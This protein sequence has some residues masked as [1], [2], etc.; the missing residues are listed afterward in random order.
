MMRR[1]SKESNQEGRETG[2]TKGAS[3]K[4]QTPRPRAALVTWG[5]AEGHRSMGISRSQVAAWKG[6]SRPQPQ[7]G[8]G[9]GGSRDEI[10]ESS[11]MQR[12]RPATRRLAAKA[13]RTPGS[14][15]TDTALTWLVTWNETEE[16]LGTRAGEPAPAS[17]LARSPTAAPGRA[18]LGVGLQRQPALTLHDDSAGRSPALTAAAAATTASAPARSGRRHPN[19]TA[20]GEVNEGRSPIPGSSPRPTEAP[21]RYHC[22]M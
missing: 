10:P 18:H 6:R 14:G 7:T 9:G 1:N 20:R 2:N 16:G 4:P 3:S 21:L 11:G 5:P 12:W 13:E 8:R 17:R 15:L 19:A 22:L